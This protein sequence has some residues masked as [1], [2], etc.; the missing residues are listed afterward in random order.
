MKDAHLKDL[1]LR[2]GFRYYHVC[3]GDVETNV[4]LIDRRL[5]WKSQIRYLILHDI[6]T[7]YNRV[8]FCDACGTFKSKEE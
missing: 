7:P 6:W 2:L 3:H 4:F 1:P 8:P 5:T